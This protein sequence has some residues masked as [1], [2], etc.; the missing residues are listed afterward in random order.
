MI[1]DWKENIELKPCPFCGALPRKYEI[2]AH[3]HA[4]AEFMPDHEGSW[5][6]ECACGSGFVAESKEEV[7]E[8][9]NR[10]FE[11]EKF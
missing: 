11:V 2:E 4:I 7:I 9:W 8:K 5:C 10:R 3:T 6:I 1:I